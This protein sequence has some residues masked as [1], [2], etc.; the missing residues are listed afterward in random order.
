MV[1]GEGAPSSG[2]LTGKAES[3]SGAGHDVVQAAQTEPG[4]SLAGTSARCPG[5]VVACREQRLQTPVRGGRHGMARSNAEG[6]SKVEK[7]VGD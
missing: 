2:V 1:D 6:R 3:G 4:H 7:G 5:A